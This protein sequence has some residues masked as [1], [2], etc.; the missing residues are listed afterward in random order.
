MRAKTGAFYVIKQTGHRDAVA[1]SLEKVK[2][3]IQNRLYRERRTES[4]QTFVDN[5]RA[6]ASIEVNEENLE[7]VDIDTREADGARGPE[8]H[9]HQHDTSTDH[10]KGD[11]HGKEHK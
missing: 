9:S 3:Q 10:G 5:L 2:R 7:A 6:K 8:P 11:P 4:Q 1:Q